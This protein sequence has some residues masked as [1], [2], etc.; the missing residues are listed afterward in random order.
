[1]FFIAAY[2]LL[3]QHIALSLA[4]F[5]GLHA[6]AFTNHVAGVQNTKS[7]LFKTAIYSVHMSCDP[8]LDIL[9]IVQTCPNC[10]KRAISE[11]LRRLRTSGFPIFGTHLAIT[12]IGI[13]ADPDSSRH[14]LGVAIA[15]V[16]LP[17]GSVGGHWNPAESE[18]CGSVPSGQRDEAGWSAGGRASQRSWGVC[19]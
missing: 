4:I 16:A 12:K 8:V 10:P 6:P 1:L 11:K 5:S 13:R 2:I 9:D 15:S 7:M 17:I 3:V 19:S 14:D 18:A